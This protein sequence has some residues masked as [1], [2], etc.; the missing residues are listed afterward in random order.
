MADLANESVIFAIII[1]LQ[2]AAIA[3]ESLAAGR[4]LSQREEAAIAWAGDFLDGVDRK[5][6]TP[7]RSG[8]GGGM[9]SQATALRPT[10]YSS[11]MSMS[12]DFARN[13]LSSERDIYDFL[14]E[15]YEYMRRPAQAKNGPPADRVLLAAQLLTAMSTRLRVRLNNNG[16]PAQRPHLVCE[17]TWHEPALA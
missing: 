8:M 1:K 13:G 2:S 7:L 9:T 12:E 14:R 11:L 3:L 15:S 6:G 17:G 10:F 16:A 5:P 4:N